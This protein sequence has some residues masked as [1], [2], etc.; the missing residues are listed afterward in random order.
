M[1][2]YVYETVPASAG[3]TPER[4]ELRQSINDA[5][6]TEH[7]KTREP[8]RRV[9]TGGLVTLTGGRAGQTTPCGTPRGGLPMA[10][11]GASSCC[12]VQ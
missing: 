7:P 4:F 2:T 6:L 12:M 10:G 8:V 1:P 11:C 5:P 3:E 9:L